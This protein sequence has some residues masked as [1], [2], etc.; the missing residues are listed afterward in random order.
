MNK[1]I[2]A[3]RGS[4]EKKKRDM[5]K[6]M[7]NNWQM[8]ESPVTGRSWDWPVN[9]DRTE[10]HFW[11][12]VFRSWHFSIKRAN[13]AALWQKMQLSATWSPIQA[14]ANRKQI[15]PQSVWMS[16][17]HYHRKNKW[18]KLSS[19]WCT[20]RQLSLLFIDLHSNFVQTDVSCAWISSNCYQHLQYSNAC[21]W[22]IKT[23]KE[24]L[25]VAIY[26]FHY[27]LY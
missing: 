4:R 13:V 23:S 2:S 22:F 20:D 7:R 12:S 6:S 1:E 15:F 27:M 5:N 25:H 10:R 14:Y 17:P 3:P 21:Y 11:L 24:N 19:Q 16:A 9:P 26:Y 18:E 8:L